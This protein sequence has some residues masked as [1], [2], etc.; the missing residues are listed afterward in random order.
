MTEQNE[1]TYIN[2]RHIL[3]REVLTT[4]NCILNVFITLLYYGLLHKK[5]H[6]IYFDKQ[7]MLLDRNV[8][9]Y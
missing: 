8:I 3:S 2:W 4:T 7:F 6:I 1:I 5:Q 9:K